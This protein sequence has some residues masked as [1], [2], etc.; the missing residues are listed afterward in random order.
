[1]TATTT[2]TPRSSTRR[3]IPLVLITNTL[4][5]VFM[6]A[7]LPVIYKSQQGFAPYA[8]VDK[9]YV[10]SAISSGETDYMHSA[11][12][13]TEIARAMAHG[14]HLS[15]MTL[16]QYAVGILAALFILNS[17]YLFRLHRRPEPVQ[18]VRGS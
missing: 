17:F 11:L 3:K 15:T 7:A 2:T 5:A 13:T 6:L 16:M 10:K 4:L 12:Q 18:A 1:M 14:S 8:Q 9:E